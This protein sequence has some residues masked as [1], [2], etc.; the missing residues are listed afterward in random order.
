MSLRQKNWKSR[1]A[2]FQREFK[3]ILGNLERPRFNLTIKI[4][5]G[6]WSAI[7]CSMSWM[8]SFRWV[9]PDR[10]ISRVIPKTIGMQK[11]LWA[12]AMESLFRCVGSRVQEI[13]RIGHS[14]ESHPCIWVHLCGYVSVN[15]LQIPISR[16]KLQSSFVGEILKCISFDF[17]R[18]SIFTLTTTHLRW[19]VSPYHVESHFQEAVQEPTQEAKWN[20]QSRDHFF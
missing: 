8:S 12:E 2:G 14:W 4:R 17:P 7:E 16:E 15:N 20:L 19:R 6:L 10:R 11:V 5:I 13:V 1:A 3:A 9:I 18:D